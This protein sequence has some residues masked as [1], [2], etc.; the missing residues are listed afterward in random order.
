MKGKKRK[1]TRSPRTPIPIKSSRRDKSEEKLS[2]DPESGHRDL[3]IK[4]FLTQMEIID[5][6]LWAFSRSVAHYTQLMARHLQ[7]SSEDELKLQHSSLLHDLGRM[8]IDRQII[9]KKGKLTLQEWETIHAHPLHTEKIL[10]VFPYFHDIIP[11]VK[12]HHEWYDGTGYPDGLM[13]EDIPFMSRIIMIADAFVAMTSERPYRTALTPDETLGV[14]EKN[15]GVQF[16]PKLVHPFITV[17]SED[18]K[19]S[20][21]RVQEQRGSAP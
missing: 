1:R 7:F 19:S 12:H 5:P 4:A 8:G 16:D 20:P 10:S 13:G 6:S 9:D 11:I 18:L 2:P 14:I 15:K 17:V 3:T 21:L